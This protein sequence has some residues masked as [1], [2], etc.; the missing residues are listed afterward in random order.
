MKKDI[1]S[2]PNIV[3]DWL[4]KLGLLVVCTA[5]IVYFLPREQKITFN[6]EEGR[7]WANSQL[8]TEFDFPIYKSE[9]VIAQETDSILRYFT[10]YFAENDTLAQRQLY[11]VKQSLEEAC[12][13]DW[14]QRTL[15]LDAVKGLYQQGI[16][17]TEHYNML[18]G[19]SIKQISIYRQR[20]AFRRPVAKVYSTKT[21]YEH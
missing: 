11:L 19:D 20:E 4:Y 1:L 15:V 21:A 6:F 13:N 10:P 7:P 8:I 17:D 12:P 3:R 14:R 2:E 9:A 18:Q 16:M 5:I